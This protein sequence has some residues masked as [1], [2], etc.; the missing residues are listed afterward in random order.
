MTIKLSELLDDAEIAALAASEARR[1]KSGIERLADKIAHPRPAGYQHKP[2]K[3]QK[4][5][6]SLDDYLAYWARDADGRYKGTEPE[7]E[8]REVWRRKLWAE[9]KLL[10]YGPDVTAWT[11]GN[12]RP[13][14]ARGTV[15]IPWFLKKNGGSDDSNEPMTMAGIA[16]AGLG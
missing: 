10:H 16:Y 13:A 15:G 8:G 11:G 7:G 1:R 12:A 2:E 4:V 3:T 5:T 9:L 14:G 6:M